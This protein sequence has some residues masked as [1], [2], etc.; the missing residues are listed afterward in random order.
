MER[1]REVRAVGPLQEAQHRQRPRSDSPFPQPHAESVTATIWSCWDLS[2][3]SLLASLQVPQLPQLPQS[4]DMHVRS[5]FKL[6][7]G[8]SVS[9]MVV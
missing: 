2:V 1:Q 6:S 7:V 4:T 5:N 8:A 9:V 3:C